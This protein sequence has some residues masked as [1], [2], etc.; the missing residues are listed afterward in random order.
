MVGR[1]KRFLYNSVIGG[2]INFYKINLMVGVSLLLGILL[3]L[4]LGILTGLVPGL[5]PNLVSILLLGLPLEPLTL[6]VVIIVTSVVNTF[7]DFIPSILLGA[8]EPSTALSILPGHKLLL[9]GRG[10]EALFLTVIGGY[11]SIIIILALLVPIIF[12][13]PVIYSLMRP[14]IHVVLILV[15]MYTLLRDRSPWALL[16]L[17]LSGSL[18]YV[19]LSTHLMDQDKVLFP[20]LT[21][22]FGI[23]ALLNS[24]RRRCSIPVQEMGVGYIGKSKVLKGGL[25]GSVSGMLVGLLP[26]IG[27][28]QATYL[29]QEILGEKDENGFLISMG[30]INTA[31]AVLSILAL[32]LIGNPRSGAAVV[33]GNI[34]NVQAY[35]IPLLIGV[36]VLASVAGGVL[37]LVLGKR[38]LSLLRGIDYSLISKFVLIFLLSMV[39][40]L[41]GPVGLMISL[42]ASSIGLTCILSGTR[43][44]YMMGSIL[45]PTIIYFL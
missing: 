17:V 21:G 25:V 8:P 36:V 38:I 24:M 6:C 29:S 37:T 32:W 26:G 3:G 14:F 18:G 34:M 35:H 31:D 2:L 19:A 7:L 39:L 45:I 33:I 23:G 22:L 28:A 9:L 42:I 12:L 5:H 27:A 44:S 16:I 10:F 43:R 13:V 15:I 4:A 30:G 40:F 1:D 11:M 41:S 20:L